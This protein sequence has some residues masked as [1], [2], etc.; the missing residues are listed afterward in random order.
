MADVGL[1]FVSA[2]LS[3]REPA[4]LAWVEEGDLSDMARTVYRWVVEYVR[5]YS[6]VPPFELVAQ[7][8]GVGLPP[9]LGTLEH[10]ADQVLNFAM[11]QAAGDELRAV[12]ELLQAGKGREAID[13]LTG[14]SRRL[15][16]NYAGA[17]GE[18]ESSLAE[19]I[20]DLLQDYYRASSTE[21]V[22]TGIPTPWQP[23]D[24]MTL[25]WQPG[26]FYTFLGRPHKGKTWIACLFADAARRAGVPVLFLSLEMSRLRI[27]RRLACIAAGV[28]YSLVR[29]GR[30]SPMHFDRYQRCLAALAQPTADVVVVGRRSVR[31][32]AT[33]ETKIAETRPKLVIVDGF[34]NLRVDEK[35][36]SSLKENERVA[37]QCWALKEASEGHQLPLIGV[38]QFNRTVGD[39]DTRASL[40]QTGFSDAM[41]RDPD[42]SFA[43]F[44]PQALKAHSEAEIFCLKW[45]EE[46]LAGTS[47]RIGFCTNRMDFGFRGYVDHEGR[48]SA[49]P[50]GAV[51]L[52]F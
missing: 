23:L 8:T 33:V 7:Y 37:E 18:D 13:A 22:V 24:Q 16:A 26:E 45:R 2:V 3:A 41:A 27:H 51:D 36:S 49:S 39:E 50:P 4:A 34:Y 10:H 17:T 35:G 1:E 48:L 15:T 42:G 25:G 11:L 43:I 47:L 20:Q 29:R 6:S 5:R 31:S 44:M 46:D 19:S 14:A 21:S 28:S 52:E 32:L 30:L 9:A 40:R 12:A 38:S